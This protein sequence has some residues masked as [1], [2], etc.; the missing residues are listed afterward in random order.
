LAREVDMS[1]TTVHRI[2]KTHKLYP[3]NVV[4]VQGL[5]PSDYKKRLTLISKM[6]LLYE[7]DRS[8]FLKILWTDEG[9]FFNNGIMNPRN[10][11]F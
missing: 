2:L 11:H 9:K 7:L 3:Y 6:S 1:K 8:I 4:L 10:S 5:R